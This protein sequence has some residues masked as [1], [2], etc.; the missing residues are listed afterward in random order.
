MLASGEV[1]GVYFLGGG[2][3]RI[4]NNHRLCLNR[5][6]GNTLAS[7]VSYRRVVTQMYPAP[8]PGSIRRESQRSIDCAPGSYRGEICS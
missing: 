7:A 8:T 2:Y 3:A 1:A 6:P 5:A 4:P